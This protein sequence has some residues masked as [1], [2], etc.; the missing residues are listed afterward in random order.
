MSY[1][2]RRATVDDAPLLAVHRARIWHEVGEWDEESL[3]RQIPIWTEFIRRTVSDGTYIAWIAEENGGPIG[4]G[5]ILV[6]L[7]IPRPGFVSE[8]AGRVQ[9][10]YVVPTQRRRGIARAI[11]ERLLAYARDEKL[12]SLTLR[13]SDDARA[14]YGS[15]G[16]SAADEMGL[17]LAP[18]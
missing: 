8:R 11:M 7:A 17:R 4:S 12:I 10:V 15:L 18:E 2:L 1:T 5:A 9:S 6:Q 3:E 13:P 16:F 14:L